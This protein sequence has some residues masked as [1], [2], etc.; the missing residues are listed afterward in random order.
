MK[1]LK[2]KIADKVFQ[3][4]QEFP[5]VAVEKLRKIALL[6]PEDAVHELETSFSGLDEN[7]VKKMIQLFGLNKVQREKAASWPEQLLAAF[8]NPFIGILL[9]IAAV[10]FVIDVWLEVP[11]ERDYKTIVVVSVMI[12]ISVVLRFIQEYRSSQAAEK[13][14]RLVTN[15][16]TV[17][18]KETGKKEV[19]LEEIVP[20]DLIMLSAG[21]MIPAD[22]RIIQS[23]DLF[24]NQSVLTGES[25][26]VE[27]KHAAFPDAM[28]STLFELQNICLMGTN[29]ESGSALVVA[30]NTGMNTCF[31]SISRSVT[32]KRMETSFD[33]GINKVSWL[34]IRFMLVMVPVIFLLNGWVKG[35]WFDALLFAIAVAVGLT[36][37]MLPMIVT[38]N[39]AKGA[40]NM[41]RYKVIIKR[42]N[43]IQNIGAMDVLCTDKTGTLT[44]DKVVLERHINIL[45]YEDD[46]VLSWAYLN[47]FHQTGVKSL[48]DNAILT[49]A[50]LREELQVERKFE[51]IDEIPFDFQRRRLS[52]ILRK[53][54][55][56]H[57]LICKGAVEEMLQV[58]SFAFDPGEDKQLQIF[59]D[60]IIP[61]NESARKLILQETQKMNE[62]GMRVLLLAV[63]EFESRELNYSVSDESDLVIAGLI[64][65]LDPAKP[66]ASEALKR[67]QALGV[68]VKV[69]T[70]DNETVTK[71]ICKD[72][73]IPVGNI[74]LGSELESISDEELAEKIDNVSI[75]AKLSPLQKNRLVKTLQNKGHTVGFLGDGIND[76]G[77]LKGADVGI[78]VDTATDIAKESADIIL[79]ENDLN[80]I[81]KGVVYGRRTFG[82]IL[83]Y[84]KMTTSSNFGNMFSMLGAS[85]FLPFL[86][87]L[88]AQ[89]LLQNLLYDISQTTIP[90]DRV[91]EEYIN[92]PQKW[93]AGFLS[94]F[95]L[96]F[97][98]ISSVFDYITFALMFFFFKANS[99]QHQSLFQTG[100]FVEGLLSQTLIVHLIRTRRIPFIQSWA[101]PPVVALT[102]LIMAVGI[103]I[104]FTP[105]A[106]MLGMVPLPALYFPFLIAI[107]TG[108]AFLTQMIKNWFIK[109]YNVF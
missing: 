29:V 21:D 100:W 60:A 34:L 43:A 35:N 98:P 72:V 42:L 95:M 1:K 86:P 87:M 92:T 36:P 71:K 18:R 24:V 102:A 17:I 99:P 32:G 96:Y 67:L 45:G 28:K 109:I 4:N 88:P 7:D 59:S 105:V 49:H 12:F 25:M 77:A 15:T 66:S 33:K 107:L 3:N 103:T 82:N 26:P 10:S 83:K 79:L 68:T 53:E 90:W 2:N 89:L 94:K 31:G 80:V 76:A 64:G 97:G 81:R 5:A 40:V 101:T 91:D 46:E 51:K 14:K 8:I 65:F 38:A 78:S 30:V 44:I 50:E 84:I 73:G 48:L 85:A 93:D 63:R 62:D 6:N 56:R 13:L 20:G 27:K 69:L 41:S 104:P 74:M 19:L 16:A 58:S 39:L 75:F 61:L 22:C 11:E 106:H 47:S 55:G 108:Y 9:I 57:I 52:V 37:E 54:D 23:K 70:G